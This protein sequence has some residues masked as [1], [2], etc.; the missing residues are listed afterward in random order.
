[1]NHSRNDADELIGF[2]TSSCGVR[3][4]KGHCERFRFSLQTRKYW[5]VSINSV[6]AKIKIHQHALHEQEKSMVGRID[7]VET[8]NI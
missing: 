1:M 7:V 2:D 5:R 6:A 8:L 3:R 4:T